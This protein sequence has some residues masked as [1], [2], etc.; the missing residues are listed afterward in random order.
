MTTESVPVDQPKHPVHALTTYELARYR[1]QLEH[2]L[3]SLPT[4][5]PLREQLQHQLAEV[6]GEQ[7][8]RAQLQQANRA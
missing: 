5:A 8:A 4:Q 6:L 3:K 1:R 2:A 7:H